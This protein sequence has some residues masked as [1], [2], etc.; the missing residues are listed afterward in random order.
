MQTQ[1]FYVRGPESFCNTDL[2]ESGCVRCTGL[3]TTV[4]SDTNLFIRGNVVWNFARE[5]DG[6]TPMGFDWSG[7]C[8]AGSTCNETM[9]RATNAINDPAV[10]PQLFNPGAGDFR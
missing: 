2:G 3:P 10:K 8:Q 5:A 4:V 7:G 9:V 6:A 1:H